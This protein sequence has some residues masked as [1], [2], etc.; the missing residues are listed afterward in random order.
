MPTELGVMVVVIVAWGGR[1]NGG[2][3]VVIATAWDGVLPSV[4]LGCAQ[5]S[6]RT[7]TAAW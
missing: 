1:E 2:G 5:S 4:L 7:L 3:V 6:S